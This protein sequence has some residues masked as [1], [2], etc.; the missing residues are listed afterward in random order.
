MRLWLGPPPPGRCLPLLLLLAL[1]GTYRVGSAGRSAAAARPRGSGWAEQGSFKVSVWP[2]DSVVEYGGSVWINCSTTCPDV[3]AQGGLETSLTK[4]QSERGPGWAA[5]HLVNITEWVSHLQC[6]VTCH[7]NTATVS[8]RLQ[9]TNFPFLPLAPGAPERVELEPL[10]ELELGRAHNLTCRVLNVAPDR[11]L[12]VTLLL[13]GQTLH[14]ETFQN[15]T[16]TGADTVTV[17]HTIT[18]RQWDHGQE[19]TCHTALDLRPHG[20]LI[21]RS[22]PALPLTVFGEFPIA[23]VCRAVPSA[24][25]AWVLYQCTDLTH[26]FL[27]LLGE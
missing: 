20:L 21:Q 7:G 17:T 25:A 24:G 2:E 19:A 14:T 27:L 12:S 6:Y 8:Q 3:N 15:S 10:T 23:P 11:H 9:F 13:G 18:P 1:S 16:R 26:S 5:F 4:A 22:S